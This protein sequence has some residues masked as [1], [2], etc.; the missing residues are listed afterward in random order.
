MDFASDLLPHTLG[1]HLIAFIMRKSKIGAKKRYVVVASIWSQGNGGA[2]FKTM[3][4]FDLAIRAVSGWFQILRVFFWFYFL[5]FRLN[6]TKLLGLQWDAMF[7][8]SGAWNMQL[9]ALT[10]L[11]QTVLTQ[12]RFEAMWCQ[13]A[14]RCSTAIFSTLK[15]LY[16]Y[17]L[18]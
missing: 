5:M 3:H 7:S 11:W 12:S 9:K 14:L 1:W 4:W 10:R 15:H 17:I 18:V 13:K 8:V 6:W 2:G 16:N